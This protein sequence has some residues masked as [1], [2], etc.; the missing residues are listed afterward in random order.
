MASSLKQEKIMEKIAFFSSSPYS[1]ILV[2]R[3]ILAHYIF[4]EKL[5]YGVN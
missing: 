3:I 1:S 5:F 2:S 4:L